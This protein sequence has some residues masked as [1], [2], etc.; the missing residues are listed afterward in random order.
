MTPDQTRQIVE[1]ALHNWHNF[2]LLAWIITC[3]ISTL[4]VICGV[5]LVEQTKNRAYMKTLD[6]MT[7]IAGRAQATFDAQLED[8]KFKNQIRLA[9]LDAR[10]AAHQT[11][12][13][14]WRELLSTANRPNVGIDTA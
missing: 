14:L 3:F 11:A 7:K 9:A 2:P 4:G 12:Y 8:H 6:E 1:Q 13:S 10:L 5:Y